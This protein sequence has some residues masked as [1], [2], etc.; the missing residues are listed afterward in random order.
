MMVYPL[1]EVS[2][3]PGP[4]GQHTVGIVDMAGAEWGDFNYISFNV[5]SVR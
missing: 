1:Q 4:I 2:T 3:G 5:K